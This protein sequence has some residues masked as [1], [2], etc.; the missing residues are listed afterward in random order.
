MSTRVSESM[1][2]NRTLY[3]LNNLQA[4]SKT[5]MDQM[6]SQKKINRPSDDPTG[7][8][9]VL[10]LR[11]V[12]QM[13]NQ[14]T[15]NIDSSD[16]WLKMTESKL[17]SLDDLLVNAR[18]LAT[19]QATAT[20]TADTRRITANN[21]QQ[22]TDQMFSIA[23]SQYMDRYIFAGG[24]TDQPPFAR[25]ETISLAMVSGENNGFSG[26]VSRSLGLMNVAAGDTLTIE[27]STYTAVASGA[28]AGQFDV[29]LTDADTADNLRAAIALANP[30]VYT[31][32]D[33]GTADLTIN[34]TDGI[35]LG[36]VRTNNG[37]HFSSY[38]GSTNKT[39]A[40]KIIGGGSLGTATY[41]ISQ[42][43]GRTW[44]A[45]PILTPATGVV[46][47]GD[48]VVMHFTAGTFV[49]NDIFYVRAS[50]SG[51][52]KGDGEEMSTDIGQGLPF[53]Y[54]I[55]GE[56]VFTNKGKG[57]MDIFEVMKDLKTALEN[58][59]QNGIQ[60]QIDKLKA[61]DDQVLLNRTISG[62]RMN[63]MELAKNYQAD[64]DQR[65]AEMLSKIE[66]ADITKLVTDL[67]STQLALEASYKVATM[68][69]QGMTILNFL[70]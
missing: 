64:Y 5:I 16:A 18:E 61:A 26:T 55:S 58:N 29:G 38:T 41:E 22:L 46:N 60:G 30:G 36:A 6:S 34:R 52:Y 19:A 9:K 17:S 15:K 11:Y 12:Q 7:V 35:T 53:A 62:A 27:G 56:A 43:G 20:A 2:F 63:R 28:G 65:A 8:G 10:N 51:L 33:A 32:G 3:N 23:N 1:K 44:D 47:V 25:E 57:Q 68:M 49:A 70:K 37:A 40:M 14:Y 39:Y 21:I 54:G 24:R 67:A 50:T 13:N 31:L 42:D 66:D 48:G 45:P 69:T 59:D 4:A